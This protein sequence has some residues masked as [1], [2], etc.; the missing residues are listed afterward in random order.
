MNS[1][2]T[3]GIGMVTARLA[4]LRGYTSVFARAQ[5]KQ[6]LLTNAPLGDIPSSL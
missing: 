6:G 1:G 4:C 5:S 3:S 2:P